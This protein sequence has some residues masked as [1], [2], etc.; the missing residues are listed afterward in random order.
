MEL[1]DNVVGP[2]KVDNRFF[3]MDDIYPVVWG[4]SCIA[5]CLVGGKKKTESRSLSGM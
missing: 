2:F 4:F 3:T 5:Q 1:L